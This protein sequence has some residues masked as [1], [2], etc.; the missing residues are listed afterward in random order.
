TGSVTLLAEVRGNE[1]YIAVRDTGPGIPE[2]AISTIF[3]RFEQYRNNSEVQGTGLGLDISQRL[4]QLH[5]TAITIKS[6][7]GL[8]STFAFTL[9]LATA[10][11]LAQPDDDA[12]TLE[13]VQLF[14][15]N[16]VLEMTAL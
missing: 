6:E 4:A 8:G 11:Q 14:S 10:A 13:N 15:G 9:P 12:L 1:V 2:S 5:G 7:I 3:D 16:A